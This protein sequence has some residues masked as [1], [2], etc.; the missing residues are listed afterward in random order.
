M[1]D[2]RKV[3][4]IFIS[5]Y[6]FLFFCPPV[7]FFLP[8]FSLSSGYTHDGGWLGNRSPDTQYFVL[9]SVLTR[10]NDAPWVLG[11]SVR[12]PGQSLSYW[13]YLSWHLIPRDTDYDHGPTRTTP[14]GRIM[15]KIRMR[16]RQ[17]NIKRRK[18]SVEEMSQRRLDYSLTNQR[19]N[20]R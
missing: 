1:R 15:K 19:R 5:H 20:G 9:E 3:K 12:W 4:E 11:W 2:I 8:I 18:A 17:S 13:Y 10:S 14:L 16:R 7:L 6:L